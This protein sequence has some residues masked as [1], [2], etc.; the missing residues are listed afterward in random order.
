MELFRPLRTYPAGVWKDGPLPVRQRVA[1][2]LSPLSKS[3]PCGP[4]FPGSL[5]AG[6][7][8]ICYIGRPMNRREAI[9]MLQTHAEAVKALG[10]TSLYLFGS[11]ARDEAKIR[12]DL[13]L[14][15][16]YRLSLDMA[17]K[18]G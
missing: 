17:P 8:E 7:P 16:D 18:H 5:S 14:F 3:P 1:P 15:V 11:V 13:D 4:G 10:A 12:S 6:S 2:T 9:A